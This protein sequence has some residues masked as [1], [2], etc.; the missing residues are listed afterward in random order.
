VFVNGHD[1]QRT[2]SFY[3][4]GHNDDTNAYEQETTKTIVVKI[5][6]SPPKCTVSP[7]PTGWVNSE[8]SLGF[9]ATDPNMPDAS[10]VRRLDLKVDGAT[11]EWT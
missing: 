6:T 5:D 8:Q 11:N 2:F 10:G 9:T 3:S 1:G 7:Q 4:V